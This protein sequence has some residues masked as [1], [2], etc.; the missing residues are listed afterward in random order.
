MS[1][2]R[3]VVTGI[4]TVNPLGCNVENSWKNLI[5]GKSGIRKI[6]LFDVSELPDSISKIAGEVK[7][8]DGEN[9]LNMENFIEKKEQRK[10]DKFIQFSLVAATEAVEDSGLVVRRLGL[11]KVKGRVLPETLY[12]L[13]GS[14]DQRFSK[15]NIEQWSFWLTEIE[16][17]IASELFCPD[18]FQKDRS[19]ING[20]LRRN[21]LGDDGVWYLDEK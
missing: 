16:S 1:E 15:N 2:K 3:V 21:L 18:C 5:N 6:S 10:M 7:E 19:T 12:A 20:W 13:G 8:G 4:G 11:F 9:E 17:G 14:D